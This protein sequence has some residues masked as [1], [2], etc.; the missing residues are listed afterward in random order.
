MC[1]YH[2]GLKTVS[3]ESGSC[4]YNQVYIKN[5]DI[6]T[7][8]EAGATEM[9]VVVDSSELSLY[10]YYSDKGEH[11]RETGVYGHAVSGVTKSEADS[12]GLY[13]LTVVLSADIDHDIAFYLGSGVESCKIYEISFNTPA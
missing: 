10:K 12:N 6:K 9:K 13:T 3:G 4:D 5:A 8:L 11:A 1:W 2:Y 7:F